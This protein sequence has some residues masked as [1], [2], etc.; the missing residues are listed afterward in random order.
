MATG[1]KFKL[2]GLT[3]EAFGILVPIIHLASE[4]TDHPR[5]PFHIPGLFHTVLLQPEC[6]LPHL[7]PRLGKVLLTLGQFKGYLYPED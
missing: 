1:A 7:L 6:P 4:A 5:V 3:Y 2:I